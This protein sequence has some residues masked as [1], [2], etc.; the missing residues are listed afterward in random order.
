MAK[1]ILMDFPEDEESAENLLYP[2]EI[3]GE[4]SISDFMV[5]TANEGKDN[6]SSFYRFQVKI[7]SRFR[8][9]FSAG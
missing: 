6:E 9:H 7:P 5:K 3:T 4:N 2:N 8:L 1:V